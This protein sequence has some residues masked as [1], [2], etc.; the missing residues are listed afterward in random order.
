MADFPFN[1]VDVFNACGISVEV[2]GDKIYFDCPECGATKKSKA[3]EARISTGVYNCAKCGKFG[4]GMLKLYQYYHKCDAKTA[5]K[6]MREYVGQPTYSQ[7]KRQNELIESHAKRIVAQQSNLASEDIINATYRRFLN[8]CYLSKKHRESLK[9]RGLSDKAITHFGFKSA[10]ISFPEHRRI[11]DTLLREGYPLEGV[12]GFYLNEKGFWDFNIK[13]R[14]SGIMIPYISLQNKLLGFQIRLDKPFE[15]HKKD[16]TVKSTRYLWFVSTDLNKGCSRSTVPHIT[17]TRRVEKTIFFTEGALKADVASFL[18]NR[19]F[20]AIAGVTQYS[21]LPDIF[22][23]LKTN[24]VR[25]IVDCFDADYRR[26]PNVAAARDR[27]KLEIL[28][29]G[30]QYYRL[31]WDERNGKGIDDF[32]LNIPRGKRK[33]ELFDY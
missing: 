26:N 31:D 32:L 30:L 11:I 2:R 24:G 20:L 5:N 25:R 28:K 19:E 10:P 14:F 3:L 22:K 16:G 7:R 8:L 12:P 1:I 33:Y 17:S 15:E 9:N 27:L 6:E 23:T 21:I 29:A 4:G 13:Q 18:S